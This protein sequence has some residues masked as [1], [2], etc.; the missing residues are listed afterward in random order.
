VLHASP[1]FLICSP[2]Q[3]FARSASH[4]ASHCAIPSSPLLPCPTYAQTSFL[5]TRSQSS[6]V[7]APPSMWDNQ[8][9]HPYKTYMPTWP[10]QGKQWL[11]LPSKETYGVC[12]TLLCQCSHMLV[13][14]PQ[15]FISVYRWTCYGVALCVSYLCRAVS[16]KLCLKIRFGPI[17]ERVSPVIGG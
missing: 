15:T 14:S 12:F 6:S 11:L 10:E 16:E 1:I 3:Y 5:I 8:V 17:P 2:E 4:K 9:S 13:T 7:Y